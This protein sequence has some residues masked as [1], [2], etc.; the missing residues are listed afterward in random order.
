MLVRQ[1]KVGPMENFVY[2]VKDEASHDAL[3]V[4]SGWETGPILRAMEEAKARPKYVVATHEHFD[5]VSTIDELAD[6]VG[7]DV[8]AYKGSP[9]RCDIEAADMYELKLGGSAAKVIH[10]PGHT[11]DSLCLYDGRNVFTG[12][13]LFV[14]TIGKFERS[15]AAEIYQSLRS[16]MGLPGDTVM[17]PGHDYGDV[18]SR[19]LAEER[20][21]NPYL[22]FSDLDSFLSAF[23]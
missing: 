10:T 12:D 15:N 4:D 3:I 22:G 9:V 2:I 14:G 11:Y 18:P 23:S 20:R 21:S 6:K 16:I 8:V 7:A 1:M 17:Y 5:H 13:T 19:T